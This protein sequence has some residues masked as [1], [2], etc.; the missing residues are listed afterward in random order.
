MTQT[1]K[2]LVTCVLGALLGA[3][4]FSLFGVPQ[5]TPEQLCLLVLSASL[6]VLTTDTKLLLLA[7]ICATSSYL[8]MYATSTLSGI[9]LVLSYIIN[10]T[11]AL[12]M[13]D[14]TDKSVK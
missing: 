3:N 7:L 2:I 10:V 12:F 4:V 11:L 13:L 5:L 1:K 6:L 8:G 14:Q 9:P